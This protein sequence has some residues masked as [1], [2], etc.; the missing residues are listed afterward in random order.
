MASVRYFPCAFSLVV[1]SKESLGLG[2]SNFVCHYKELRG[3]IFTDCKLYKLRIT[4]IEII[5]TVKVISDILK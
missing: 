4:N 2:M 3:L 1:T 5:Q